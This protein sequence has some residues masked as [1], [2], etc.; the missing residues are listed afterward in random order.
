MLQASRKTV[1][2]QRGFTFIGVI[3]FIAVAAFAAAVIAPNLVREI[4]QEVSEAED[5]HLKSIALGIKT[6]IRQNHGFPPTLASLSPH[7]VSYSAMSLTQNEHGYSRYY[8]IHPNMSSFNN[9]TGLSAS[10]VADARFLLISHL[11]QDAAP[12]IVT[13]AQFETWWT[14][15]ERSLP[16]LKIHR[17]NVGHFFHQLTMTGDG[18]GGS[19]DINGT[20]TNSGG[21]SLSTHTKYHLTSTNPGFDENST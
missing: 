7:Y 11:K 2:A 19:Y 21:T 12:T 8:V 18:D 3:G 14:T 10:D 4:D 6:Y 15:D 17:G 16:S 1:Y 20:S 9:A 13:A 5:K